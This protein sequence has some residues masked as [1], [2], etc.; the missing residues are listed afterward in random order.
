MAIREHYSHAIVDKHKDKKFAL[1]L[2]RLS[3]FAYK[4]NLPAG[5]YFVSKERYF[6]TY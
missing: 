4:H 5:R 6:K 2:L 3:R 1:Q